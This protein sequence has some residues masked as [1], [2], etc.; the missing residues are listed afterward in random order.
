MFLHSCKITVAPNRLVIPQE[1]LKPGL[2]A[3]CLNN[4]IFKKIRIQNTL[5]VFY[6]SLCVF[7]LLNVEQPPF[8]HLRSRALTLWRGEAACPVQHSLLCVC[9]IAPVVS[10]NLRHHP[11]PPG[12]S[13]RSKGLIRFGL[14]RLLLPH[15]YVGDAVPFTLCPVRMHLVSLHPMI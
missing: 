2:H 6:Y 1:H 8:P 9:L 14:K 11:P 12:I 13:V 3:Y 4:V 5:Y 15:P 7:N 10:F